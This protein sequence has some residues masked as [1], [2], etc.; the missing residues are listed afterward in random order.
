[1]ANP[2][3]F[4]VQFDPIHYEG[5]LVDAPL[6]LKI[7]KVDSY[8]A[9]VL[10]SCRRCLTIDA[11]IPAVITT[12]AAV[13]YLAGFFSGHESTRGDYEAFMA[14]YFPPEY[15]PFLDRIYVD[16]RC[17][18]VHNLVAINPW[19][20]S[21]ASFLLVTD[22]PNHLAVEG[23][24]VVWSIR[25]FVE[26]TYTAWLTYSKHLMSAPQDVAAVSRFHNRFD[27]LAGTGALMEKA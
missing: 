15:T 2:E 16:L 27:K 7:Y 11:E 21:A 24:R 17:G 23:D 22:V 20:S 8:V 13:D 10:K 19:R 5:P 12:L 9:E 1:M 14:T 25:T 26:H 4:F 18:L 3:D 6:P